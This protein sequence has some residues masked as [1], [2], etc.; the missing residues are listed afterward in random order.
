MVSTIQED[1]VGGSWSEEFACDIE[2]KRLNA[3]KMM[4]K[5]VDFTTETQ[6]DVLGTPRLVLFQQFCNVN[7]LFILS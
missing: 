5:V 1:I 2:I 7:I 6:N 4:I 3:M